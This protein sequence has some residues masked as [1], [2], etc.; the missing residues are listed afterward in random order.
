MAVKIGEEYA[1]S[2]EPKMQVID[3][4]LS[5][6]EAMETFGMLMPDQV[7]R[8]KHGFSTED[9]GDHP[10]KGIGDCMMQRQQKYD[11]PL[12]SG[13]CLLSILSHID[14]EGYECYVDDNK[15]KMFYKVKKGTI[16]EVAVVCRSG[17][18]VFAN[19]HIKADDY[20]PDYLLKAF[21]SLLN[22]DE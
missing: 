12:E 2:D 8:R 20:E 17:Q 6:R 4:M 18:T 15:N 14:P 22:E 1:A 7:E 11:L 16:K 5:P 3:V 21:M 13:L 19:C 10:V 9:M